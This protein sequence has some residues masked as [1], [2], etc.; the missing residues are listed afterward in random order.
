MDRQIAPSKVK[1]KK[2]LRW[3]P[4]VVLIPVLYFMARAGNEKVFRIDSNAVKIGTVSFGAFQDVVSLNGVLE[5][6]RTV[7][8]TALQGGRV[9]ELVVE[10]GAFVEAGEILM[11]LANSDLALD[12]MNRETQIIEQIN[13]LRS[14]RIQLEQN[15]RQVQEQ[16]L[17][18]KY[19]Y[20]E[21]VRTFAI[22]SNLY[23]QGAIPKG[24][25]DASKNELMYLKGLIDL[26]RERL[27]TD[28]S[29]RRMQLGRIDQSIELMERNLDAIRRSLDDLV[30]KAPI[31]GQMSQFSHEIGETKQKGESLGR[32]D[33]LDS[34]LVSTPVDQ[35][36]LNR[37]SIGQEAIADLNGA[38]YGLEVYKIFPAVENGQFEIHLR[39]T[40]NEIPNPR[41][42][43]NIRVRLSLSAMEEAL[44][45]PK[46]GYYGSTGG[47]F[48]YVLDDE[49]TARKREIEL[50]AQNPE[51]YKVLSGLEEGEQVILSSYESFGDSET[52]K[53]NTN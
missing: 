49:G 38:E 7:H 48:V 17:D 45:I 46:G 35:F 3:L 50:G 10:D 11:R 41:R 4:V 20:Q 52:I 9:E 24:D 28:E 1:R 5:P 26:T 42:G 19:R 39:F 13:N 12:F 37:V 36:Y 34:F 33:V 31:A 29:Y 44:R 18:V 30:I 6:G 2:L 14:T 43:Q 25:L 27:E 8:I 15:K 32:I 53:I 40:D 21:R 47:R 22:D 23:R 51:Y 16:L